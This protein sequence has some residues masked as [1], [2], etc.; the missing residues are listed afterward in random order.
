[1]TVSAVEREWLACKQMT[2]DALDRL[3]EL[4]G[5]TAEALM[6]LGVGLDGDRVVIPV[7][8][9]TGVV[10]ALLRY[11]PDAA[12]L[13]GKPKMLAAAGTPRELFPPPEMIDDHE[14]SGLLWLVEGEPDA[15]RMWSLGL[16]AVGAPGVGKWDAGWAARFSGRRWTVVVCLDCDQAGRK[17][18]QEVAT[19]LVAEG[20]DV[21]V[22]DLDTTRNDGYDL[23]DFLAAAVTADE[24]EQAAALLRRIAEGLPPYEPVPTPVDTTGDEPTRISIVTAEAFA[25]EDEEGAA[26]ILGSEDDALI[27][28]SS[29]TMFYGDG[30]VGKTTLGIDAAC[31]LAAGDDWLG[32]PVPKPVRV[33]LVEGE[34]PRPRFRLKLRR[35]LAHWDGQPIGDR[36][37]VLEEPWARFTFADERWREDLAAAI[38]ER[39][40]D[41]LI[42]GPLTNV[43]MEGAGL[44][45]EARAFLDL[46]GNVR[47]RSGRAL[48]VVLIHHEAKGGKVSGAW[49]GVGDTLLHV[50]ALGHGHL[51]LYVQKARWASALHQTTIKLNWADG[52]GFVIDDTPELDDDAVAEKIVAAVENNPGTGWSR[53]EDTT[54]GVSDDKRREVRDRLLREGV[55]VNVAKGA[56][57]DEVVLDHCPPKRAARLYPATDP[58]LRNLRRESAAVPPQSAADRGGGDAAQLRRAAALKEPHVAPQ[59]TPA[60]FDPDEV[61]RPSDDLPD[62]AA[63]EAA[64]GD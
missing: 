9:T 60:I 64:G 11:Q 38:R 14:A 36:L 23:S 3:H 61:E 63:G 41:V 8:D 53:V 46:V 44:I 54:R 45:A 34:G 7:R 37:Q 26:V 39:E 42:V 30:G 20:V 28:E 59:I 12:L 56:N 31:H 25:A 27:T 19:A 51:R 43:G 33:L 58:T 6:R 40:I 47:Q 4:R 52:E 48:A 21:R 13:N 5:W 18:A 2:P 17:R 1:M 16:A 32:I 62:D 50:T 10:V 35:K 49:E 15:I 22:L 57:G 55:I 24:R 29:D